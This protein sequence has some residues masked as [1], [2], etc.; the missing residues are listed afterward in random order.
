MIAART[1]LLTCTGL[2]LF[3]LWP[4]GATAQDAL[5]GGAALDA[6]LSTHGGRINPSAQQE[7]YRARNMLVTGNVIGGRGFRG[8]VGYTAESDFRGFQGSDD[9]YAWRRD[10]A[11][12][13]VNFI[14]FGNSYQKLRFG[15][16]IG[17]L[18][19]RRTATGS[20][21]WNVAETVYERPGQLIDAQLRLDQLSFA[22]STTS[23][24]KVSAE[25]SSVGYVVQQI[26]EDGTQAAFPVQAS[27]L[28]GLTTTPAESDPQSIGLTTFDMVRFREDIER[29][30]RGDSRVGE[31]FRINYQDLLQADARQMGDVGDW[32]IDPETLRTRVEPAGDSDFKQILERVAERRARLAKIEDGEQA[33][34]IDA[35]SAELDALRLR[36][37]GQDPPEAVDVGV[38]EPGYQPGAEPGTGRDGIRGLED[39]GLEGRGAVSPFVEDE[40]ETTGERFRRLTEDEDEGPP[41]ASQLDVATVL[42][43]GQRVERLAQEGDQDRFNE[44]LASAEEH[45]RQGEYF[46][47]ER[48]FNRALRFTPGH[49]LAT[50]G[51]AHAQIGA[52]LYLSASVTL[53]G[54]FTYQP[55][56]IDV[57]YDPVLVPD[58]SRLLA[59]LEILQRRVEMERDRDAAALVLAYVGRLLEDRQVIE[60][61]LDVLWEINPDD[62]LPP[63]LRAI[64]L[65]EEEEAPAAESGDA[66]DAPQASEPDAENAEK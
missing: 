43:H 6:N 33:E 10:S 31:Y 41:M 63:L 66:E 55:E 17:L 47:A 64:W 48:R 8:S 61:G 3:L 32:R 1:I 26:S 36:L 29:G 13:D 59:A 37:V 35:L 52:G 51:L 60:H 5:G 25:P 19:Y 46:W 42:R 38:G 39:R 27:S 20:T 44:L 18:E 34:S 9:I 4:A 12:S 23:A 16:D 56:M 28:R 21:G 24:S 22:S 30:T 50:A 14:N 11:W 15:Q 53:R 2:G 7:D 45:L 58:R 40:E 65:T 62:L 54:M 49:P 57:S